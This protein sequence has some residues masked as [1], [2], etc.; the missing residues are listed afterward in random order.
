MKNISLTFVSIFILALSVQ[1]QITITQADL[2]A[3]GDTFRVS[4]GDIFQAN[5]DPVP[6]GANHTWDFSM[7]TPTAQNVDSIVDEAYPGSTFGL[8]FIDISFN[9]NRANQAQRAEIFGGIPPIPGANISNIYNFYYKNSSQ[10]KQVGI[11]ANLGGQDVPLAFDNKD[12]IYNFP[13]NYNDIDSC[14]ADATLSLT[15]LGYY[16]FTQHRV[17]TVEGWGT[18]ITPYGSFNTIKVKSVITGHDT[19]YL[20]TLGQGFGADRQL[21]NEYKWLGA[22]SG[23]PL[24]QINTTITG[25]SEV[26]TSIRY[27]DSIRPVFAGLNEIKQDMEFIEVT[28]NP[29]SDECVVKVNLQRR[30]FLRTELLDVN[31]RVVSVLSEKFMNKGLNELSISTSGLNLKPGVYFIRS[32]G[33]QTIL[34]Q[35][36]IVE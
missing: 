33:E 17:S 28:P 12:I 20:D 16:G 31:G 36:F 15:G 11:G 5:I 14:D 26:I 2:P 22:G 1:A 32:H 19:L 27:Q 35:K 18:L 13:L 9:P 10:Y 23:I 24:L 7:L 3:A 6:T 8:V 29:V 30:L 34:M 4:I 21:V 25:P